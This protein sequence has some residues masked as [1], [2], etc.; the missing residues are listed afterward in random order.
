MRNSLPLD[1]DTGKYEIDRDLLMLN[2]LSV[3]ASNS[4]GN[5]DGVV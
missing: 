3:V 4:L 1:L 2:L 5:G